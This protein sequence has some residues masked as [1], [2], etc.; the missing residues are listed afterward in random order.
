MKIKIFLLLFFTIEFFAQ[1]HKCCCYY[2][3]SDKDFKSFTNKLKEVYNTNSILLKKF[4]NYELYIKP[5]NV[6]KKITVV[7][8]FKEI[9][10]CEELEKILKETDNYFVV[11]RNSKLEIGD[12]VKDTDITVGNVLEIKKQEIKINIDLCNIK[13]KP[14]ENLKN[15]IN[16]IS[17]KKN[18]YII[19]PNDY[20]KEIFLKKEK[21][22]FNSNNFDVIFDSKK[23][24]LN[25]KL[26]LNNENEISKY[27]EKRYNIIFFIPSSFAINRGN[28][29]DEDFVKF[30]QPDLKFYKEITYEELE[31][32]IIEN[33]NLGS[34]NISFYNEKKNRI[35]NYSAKI[36]G[37]DVFYSIDEYIIDEQTS[38]E[39][40][41]YLNA[42][43]DLETKIK[44][45]IKSENKDYDVFQKFADYKK[46]I[47]KLNTNEITN[48]IGSG[49]QKELKDLIDNFLMK[50]DFKNLKLVVPNEMAQLN[51]ELVTA[52]RSNIKNILDSHFYK[53]SPG[54]DANRHDMASFIKEI[55]NNK[56]KA[57]HDSTYKNS[58]IFT[59]K[60]EYS[61]KYKELQ[62]SIQKKL[63]TLKYY[64][65]LEYENTI[66]FNLANV[67]SN[68][69]MLKKDFENLWC[70][71]K[72]SYL[73]D[74]LASIL[75]AYNGLPNN[76][77]FKI[78]NGHEDVTFSED[79]IPINSTLKITF[80]LCSTPEEFHQFMYKPKI[81][82]EHKKEEIK[83]T[84]TKINKRKEVKDAEYKKIE[85]PNNEEIKK[86]EH[87]NIGDNGQNCCNCCKGKC[88]KN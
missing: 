52:N 39:I 53:I 83:K 51:K 5:G 34:Y 82:K 7:I 31:N 32:E 56:C 13:C 81:T 19:L 2:N 87:Q 15:L 41:K 42:L 8:R 60:N 23:K 43:K 9:L 47:E 1:E 75:K 61:E 17:N 84:E 54:S 55:I 65:T 4:Q 58:F 20:F 57:E 38:K 27:F 49:K 85:Q 26:K 73:F 21:E 44:D 79:I 40:D 68:L 86:T 25:I 72:Y 33:F 62:S 50:K 64:I 10:K 80:Y 35:T 6:E 12:V 76:Y 63:D 37:I 24:E 18:D 69:N 48:L 22:I 88:C 78:E 67:K 16:Y 74:L 36:R 30:K 66:I 71:I 70:E 14:N 46:E 28:I 45:D 59:L 29:K 3:L 11:K 77:S